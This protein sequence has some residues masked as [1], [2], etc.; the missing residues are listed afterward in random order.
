MTTSG[1]TAATG[2]R[3][4]G[5]GARG[6]GDPCRPRLARPSSPSTV[7]SCPNGRRTSCSVLTA[8]ARAPSCGCSTAWNAR[9]GASGSTDVRSSPGETGGRCA[10]PRPRS[11]NARICWPRASARTSRWACAPG[12]CVARRRTPAQLRAMELVGV[13]HLA[14]RGRDKLSGGEA[15]RVS[16]ARA[17]AIEPRVLFM[18]EPMASLDPPTRRSLLA[19]LRSVIADLSIAVVWVTHDRDEAVAVAD[20]VTFLSGGQV[21]QTGPAG[22]SSSRPRTTEIATS[23]AS[24]C[25][26]TGR[27]SLTAARPVWC[28]P[29]ARASS[30]A[31]PNRDQPSAASSPRMWSCFADHPRKAAR[32][33]A[34]SAEGTVH[35]QSRL[36]AGYGG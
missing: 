20:A 5:A 2:A 32:A 16:V 11:S 1:N 22:M 10:G 34:T 21:R 36:W 15:Q 4:S 9:P 35:C 19:D 3:G 30:A 7:S 29:T 8:P 25:T 18:D 23:S 28:S 12:A 27:S 17:L 14:E 33:C 24:S 31:R 13:E 6:I 26:S